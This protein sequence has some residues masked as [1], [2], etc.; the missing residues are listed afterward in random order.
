MK[1]KR[2]PRKAIAIVGEGLTEWLYFDYIRKTRSYS[3]SL[4]PDLPKHS[5]FKSVFTRARQLKNRAYDVIFCVIDID[6]LTKEDSIPEFRRVCSKL[7]KGII[8]ITSS[9]CIEIWFLM[10]FLSSPSNHMFESYSDLIPVLKKY[11]PD[12]EKSRKY[13]EG[14]DLFT[15]MEINNGLERA[16]ENAER[17]LQRIRNDDNRAQGSYTEICLVLRQLEKCGKCSF[18]DLCFD[19]IKELSSIY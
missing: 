1:R 3:F 4:K 12:Y 7:P 13:L 2:T 11:L 18:S 8:P 5:D 10:H 15:R 6:V 16:L 17:I 19:C 9:P 14:R